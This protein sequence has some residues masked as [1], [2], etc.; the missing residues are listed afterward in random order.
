MSDDDD[1]HRFLK[2]WT[3]NFFNREDPPN[4]GNLERREDYEDWSKR[5][6]SQY[7]KK[8]SEKEAGEDSTNAFIE[9]VTSDFFQYID[10][11]EEESKKS[12]KQ[13]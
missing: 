2:G 3:R 8:E 12:K 13:K 6:L 5:F 7:E 4:Y 1:F 10:K 9:H 11:V